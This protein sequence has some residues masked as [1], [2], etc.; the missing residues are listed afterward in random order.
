MFI[1]NVTFIIE[2]SKAME[3][4]N[5]VMPLARKAAGDAPSR[6]SVMRKAGGEEA[7]DSQAMSVAY[8]VEFPTV[9][10]AEIWVAKRLNPLVAAFER[11]YAPGAMV[12]TSIFETLDF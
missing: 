11:R 4:I 7:G 1:Q 5:W 2:P 6:L 12:F 3:F 9:E 8:Q 10:E